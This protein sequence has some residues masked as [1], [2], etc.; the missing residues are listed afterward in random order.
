M[1]WWTY[2]I[3]QPLRSSRGTRTGNRTDNRTLYSLLPTPGA[4]CQPLKGSLPIDNSDK[5]LVETPILHQPV[6]PRMT[7]SICVSEDLRFTCVTNTLVKALSAIPRN[8]PL[9]P[10][11]WEDNVRIG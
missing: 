11:N 2:P 8:Y 3:A 10:N 4:L 6:A 9:S 5:V 1:D 7:Q